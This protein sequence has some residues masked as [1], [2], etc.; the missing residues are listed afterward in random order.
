MERHNDKEFAQSLYK[1]LQQATALSW[2]ILKNGY[3][4]RNDE[5][6]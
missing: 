6:H 1:R 5:A 2:W 3:E 4:V